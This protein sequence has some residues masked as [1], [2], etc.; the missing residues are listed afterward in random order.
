[1]KRS[2]L[3]LLALSYVSLSAVAAN[4]VSNFGFS[5]D[6][7]SGWS[8]LGQQEVKD[9]P[10]LFDFTNNPA[11]SNMDPTI[12]QILQQKI[13]SGSI[14]FYFH[15]GV[16]HPGFTDNI[17]VVKMLAQ[18]PTSDGD[19]QQ[20]CSQVQPYLSKALADDIKVYQCSLTKVGGKNA[21]FLEFGSEAKQ[22]RS[23]Q[24]QVQKSDNV[25]LVITGSFAMETLVQE[26]A[27]FTAMMQTLKFQ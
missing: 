4:H 8:V 27:G 6:I 12:R 24:Y 22:T 5:M 11:L 7:P 9:N 16:G 23:I 15:T 18:I 26:R 14:E 3:I 10:D 25:A 1:M 19:L 21:M 17:N 13:A 2:A 20:T